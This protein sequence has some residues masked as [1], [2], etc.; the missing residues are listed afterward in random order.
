M[1]RPGLNLLDSTEVKY[2]SP[3][4]L[5]WHEIA[6]VHGVYHGPSQ[7]RYGGM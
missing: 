6:M 2:D 4:P 7:S 5:C 1:L 3:L